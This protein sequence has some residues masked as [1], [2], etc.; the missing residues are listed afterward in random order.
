MDRKVDRY[1]RSCLPF[2]Y[3]QGSTRNCNP[4]E[5]KL[6]DRSDLR[7]EISGSTQLE[8]LA[9]ESSI[10]LASYFVTANV[11]NIHQPKSNLADEDL[12]FRLVSESP[13]DPTITTVVNSFSSTTCANPA[14]ASMV[15]NYK[16]LSLKSYDDTNVVTTS[17]TTSTTAGAMSTMTNIVA[18]DHNTRQSAA[19][20]PDEDIDLLTESLDA[21]SGS[22]SRKSLNKYSDEYR[23]KRERNNEAVRKSRKKTKLKSMETQ[24]RVM[25]LSM[26][27]EELK[28]KLSLLTKELSVL[29]SLFVNS[30][31]VSAG[32]LTDFSS[33]KLDNTSTTTTMTMIT[34]ASTNSLSTRNQFGSSPSPFTLP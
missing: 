5:E 32:N 14:T 30:G 29:K 9:N 1:S 28:T 17:T 33:N 26:E 22:N 4:Q 2:S 8:I 7:G 11:T 15:N 12:L 10:D 23:R 21:G 19:I 6:L 3:Y 20:T 25:Q 27:N 31:V 13:A 24:E 34:S 18:S 16:N